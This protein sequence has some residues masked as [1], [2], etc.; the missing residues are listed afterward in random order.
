MRLTSFVSCEA[1]HETAYGFPD[2]DARMAVS[3]HEKRC[4]HLGR[5]HG[6]EHQTLRLGRGPEREDKLCEAQCQR[7]QP[8]M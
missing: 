3:V 6:P 1:V 8:E 7:A 4:Q 2:S 5:N